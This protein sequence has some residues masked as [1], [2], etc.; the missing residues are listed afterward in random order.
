MLAL[1]ILVLGAIASF[2]S[3]SR[4]NALLPMSDPS[5]V[6]HTD[7]VI[8][9]VTTPMVKKNQTV[10]EVQSAIAFTFE[11]DGKAIDG[12]YS[13]TGRNNAPQKGETLPI[14]YLTANP[15]VFLRAE[16]YRDLPRQLK[17]L[18][19]MMIVFALVAIIVP[20]GVMHHG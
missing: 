11:V 16:E 4:L 15:H 14:A 7:A 13:V 3:Y 8:R 5:L 18:R 10:S 6:S 2:I 1:A 17:A 20:F 9:S 19:M 12:G